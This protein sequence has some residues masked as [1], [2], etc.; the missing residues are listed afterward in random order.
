[1]TERRTA[2]RY[3]LSLPVMIRVPVEQANS[4]R[5]GKTRDISTRG[6]YFTIDQDLGA[7]A[8][9]DITLTLPAEVTRGTEVFIRAMGKVIRVDKAPENNSPRVGV[10]AVIERYEIVRTDPSTL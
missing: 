5:N 10:A 7:G 9:L 2:R 4:S 3:D 8:E 1:M 6:I